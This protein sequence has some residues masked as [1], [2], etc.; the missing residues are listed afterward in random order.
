[1]EPGTEFKVPYPFI[2]ANGYRIEEE[3]PSG[4]LFA[5]PQSPRLKQFLESFR[6]GTFS[7]GSRQATLRP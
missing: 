7:Q 2:M 5:A 6:A 3:G 4:E 1:M